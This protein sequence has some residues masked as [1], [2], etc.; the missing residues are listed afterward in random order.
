[1]SRVS[2]AGRT[3]MTVA[4]VGVFLG[5]SLPRDMSRSPVPEYVGERLLDRGDYRPDLLMPFLLR[6]TPDESRALDIKGED[7]RTLRKIRKRLSLPDGF[8]IVPGLGWD[9]GSGRE[10]YSDDVAQV[11]GIQLFLVF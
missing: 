11:I 7:L 5:A 1:M 4:L 6:T 2:A 8:L 10:P 3:L 9:F